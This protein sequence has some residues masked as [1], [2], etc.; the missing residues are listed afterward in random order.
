MKRHTCLL[1]LL[2]TSEEASKTLLLALNKDLDY[3]KTVISTKLHAPQILEGIQSSSKPNEHPLH[4]AL[5]RY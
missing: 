5:D 2:K 1:E 3:Y 4:T